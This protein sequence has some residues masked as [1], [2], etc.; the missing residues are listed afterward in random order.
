[1]SIP[2]K[3]IYDKI[4]DSG[5]EITIVAGEAG[6]HNPISW[7][8]MVE[9]VELT[10]LMVG[11]EL[12]FM[13]GIA[14]KSTQDF[15]ELV[16]AVYVS[17][18]GGLIVNVGPYIPKIPQN[19]IDFCNI[20]K[21]P[22]FIM[23]WNVY[24]ANVMHLIANEITSSEAKKMELV[25]S[26]KNAIY[27]HDRYDMYI[28]IFER[29]NYDVE[30]V[31]SVAVIKAQK[32]NNLVPDEEMMKRFQ[33]HIENLIISQVSNCV[34][35][36]MRDQLILLF[37]NY[38]QKEVYGFMNKLSYDMTSFLNCEKLH[39]YIGIGRNTKSARCIYKTYNIAQKVVQYQYRQNKVNDVLSY[40]QMGISK[41]FISMD[42]YEIISEFYQDI[43]EPLV[44]Y[45]KTNNT[46]YVEFLEVFF[47]NNVSVQATAEK[48][49]LHRNSINYKVKKIEEIL[50]CNLSDFKTRTELFI[51]LSIRK[52]I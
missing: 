51:A 52:L 23:P 38:T 6:I 22:L 49:F 16:K 27:F 13:T 17:N 43:L 37:A 5:N 9:G 30:W 36:T 46:D 21:F 2:L 44:N 1:M 31:Y 41:I 32:T 15:I 34:I 26:I 33:R 3:K 24:L 45:D 4:V 29:Y 39:T 8:H 28:P 20:K 10:Q 42:D 7:M 47:E 48:L 35:F 14:L 40:Q 25:S 50:D 11:G 12:A 18:A 19:V